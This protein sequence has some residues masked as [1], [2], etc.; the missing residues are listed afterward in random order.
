MDIDQAV[1]MTHVML[2]K[3]FNA[4]FEMEAKTAA[5]AKKFGCDRPQL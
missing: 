1:K 2:K 3:K 4:H 5:K